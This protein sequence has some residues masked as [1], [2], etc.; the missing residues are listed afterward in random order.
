[1]AIFLPTIGPFLHLSRNALK[2]V[3][4]SKNPDSSLEKM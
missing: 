1:M 4:K 3:K 2:S